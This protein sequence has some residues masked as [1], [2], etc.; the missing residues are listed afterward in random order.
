VRFSPGNNLDKAQSFE[1][2]GFTI[3]VVAAPLAPSMSHRS[4]CHAN[5]LP[6]HL[7]L[8]CSN[9]KTQS[10]AIPREALYDDRPRKLNKNPR[11]QTGGSRGRK[12]IFAVGFWY[13]LARYAGGHSVSVAG[14]WLNAPCPWHG[15][16]CHDVR[17]PR[18]GIWP[19]FRGVRL[20]YCVRLEP[21]DSS[22]ELMSVITGLSSPDQA[23]PRC[24]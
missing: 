20:L 5:G 1:A 13:G 15:R 12:S 10:P 6:N 17:R 14:R 8:T 18:D 21:L 22:D 11:L 9:P 23:K 4:R 7:G 24:K 3:V 19:H 2:L 16:L